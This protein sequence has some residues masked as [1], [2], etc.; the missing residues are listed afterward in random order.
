MKALSRIVFLI[1]LVFFAISCGQKENP[2][3]KS[4]S[5]R[6]N[7][8]AQEESKEDAQSPNNGNSVFKIDAYAE[9]S[10]SKAAGFV[11]SAARVNPFDTLHRFI[12]TAEVKFR[13]P[14][15]VRS[16]I[17]IE[18]MVA[19]FGGFVT[20]SNLESKVDSRKES[21][22][23]EDSLMETI[24]Y[25]VQNV[26][27]FRVPNV[28]LDSMLRALSPLVDFID[29][30]RI[31]AEDIKLRMIANEA[32]YSTSTDKVKQLKKAKPKGDESQ[33]DVADAVSNAKNDANHARFENA[34]LQDLVDYST[35]NCHIYQRKETRIQKFGREFKVNGNLPDFWVR[36]W[37]S[38]RVGWY[39]LIDI[40]VVLSRIWFL[41]LIA[42]LVVLFVRHYNKKNKKNHR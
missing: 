1:C 12:R 29:Y 26:M 39:L 6:S 23:S 11:S 36:M 14:D 34:R 15:V 8:P 21:N 38:F 37:E 28:K 20:K 27:T 2:N 19:S 30:R 4:N 17:A 24:E 16:T 9:S 18:D 13:T 22:I 33:I 5:P 31:T 10:N 25:T 32:Y 41:F 40:I 35:V 7:S 3:E 42:A